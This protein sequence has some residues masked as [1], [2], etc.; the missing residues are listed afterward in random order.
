MNKIYC[1]IDFHKNTCTICM[2]KFDGKLVEK[3]MTVKTSNLV[4]VLSTR[5]D[6]LIGIEASGGTN[7]IVEKLKASGHDVRLINPVRFRAVGL[8]GKKTDIRDAEVIAEYLR[9]NL[10]PEVYHKG[11]TS[12]EIKSLIIMR[13]QLVNSRIN[14]VNH[15]RGILREYGITMPV[16]FENF[17]THINASIEKVTNKFIA[18]NL[19]KDVVHIK[20]LLAQQ[21]CMED[22]LNSIASDNANAQLLQSVPGIGLLGSL[23]M[24]AVVDDVSRFKNA[25]MF[26]AYIGLVPS[27]DSSGDKRRLGSITRSGSEIVRRYF[28]HGARAMLTSPSDIAKQDPNRIWA[29]RIEAKSGRNKATVALA[30]KLARIAFAVLR[31][32]KEYKGKTAK[33]LRKLKEEKLEKKQVA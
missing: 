25:K 2:K 3:I 6:L 14:L 5:R 28:I 30:H 20:S 15:V 33:K 24:L 12:R 31:D 11:K 10:I 16:G 7:D 8:G 19:A 23:I 26:A 9:T 1:G 18:V 21:E 27:E 32:K 13:E 22:E 4:Q 17:L 29:S